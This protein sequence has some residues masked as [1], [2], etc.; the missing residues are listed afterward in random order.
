MKNLKIVISKDSNENLKECETLEINGIIFTK[1][2]IK[3]T[4]ASSISDDIKDSDGKD[5]KKKE[6]IKAFNGVIVNL[7][8]NLS[9]L[10]NHH[11]ELK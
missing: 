2:V 4:S 6:Q 8:H 1:N 5:S 11:I 9:K 3:K 7:G 10:F